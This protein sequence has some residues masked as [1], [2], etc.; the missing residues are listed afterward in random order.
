MSIK[1]PKIFNSVLFISALICVIIFYLNK[2]NT[3]LKQNFFI[4]S[5]FPVSSIELVE[6]KV[7]SNPILSKK[8][9]SAEFEATKVESKNAKSTAKGKIQVYFPR[10]IVE[11][12]FPK[13]IYTLAKQNSG[14]IIENGATLKLSVSFFGNEHQYS[15][16]VKNVEKTGDGF[17]ANL[18]GRFYKIRAFLRLSFRKLMSSWGNAG[19]LL[20]ALLS[21]AKE[22]TENSF[23]DAFRNAGL[24]HILALSGMHI[25]LFGGIALF[26]GKKFWGRRFSDYFQLFA[27]IFF[28]LFAGLSPSLF[29]A[30]LCSL[31]TFFCSLLRLRRPKEIDI[32]SISF[33]VHI[34]IFPEHL[35][36]ASFLL[37]YCALAGIIIFSP[38]IKKLFSYR[39]VPFAV[40]SLSASIGAQI[41]T[42]PI[43]VKLFGAIVPIGILST[44][45]I[46]PLI[47]IFLYLGL[48]GILLCLFVPF[49]STAFNAIMNIIYDIIK[50]IAFFFSEFPKIQF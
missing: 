32:L 29:R 31:V 16:L 27:I 30:L 36:T 11:S 15:Y 28:V 9:Y 35:Q 12:V 33:L 26:F 21:G 46:S 24:S 20:L 17:E 38:T 3:K 47:T 23:S 25:S 43:C 4:S 1:L 37:S 50:A 41:A 14:F 19:G 8:F 45:V 42:I 5:V 2:D 10:E 44:F 18:L 48:L 13:K 34:R 49:L 7:I 40:N 39:I 6:G 22:Y